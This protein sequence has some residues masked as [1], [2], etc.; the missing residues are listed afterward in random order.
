MCK[1]LRGRFIGTTDVWTLRLM[2]ALIRSAAKDG[3]LAAPWFY[4]T[5]KFAVPPDPAKEN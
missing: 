2:D 4:E 3:K 5:F 1:E